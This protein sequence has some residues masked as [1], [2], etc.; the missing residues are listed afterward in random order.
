MVADLPSLKHFFLLLA[1]LRPCGQITAVL[2]EMK[3]NVQYELIQSPSILGNITI[4]A[5]A[6]VLLKSLVTIIT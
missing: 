1:R 4:T 5:V 2:A 6:R 3:L